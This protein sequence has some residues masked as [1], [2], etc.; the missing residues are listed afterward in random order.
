M[1]LNSLTTTRFKVIAD[2]PNDSFPVGS[3]L[4]RISNAT[5]DHY[6][7][8]PYTFGNTI[9][10]KTLEKYSHIF[11]KLEWWEYRADEDMPQYVRLNSKIHK[12][13]KWKFNYQNVRIANIYHD[14]QTLVMSQHDF[15]PA[16]KQEYDNF[17]N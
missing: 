17:K 10:R 4:E 13:D 3:I 15:V 7:V 8:A 9:M 14:Q 5:N 1:N 2:Y 6:S 12:V 11:Q 16:T